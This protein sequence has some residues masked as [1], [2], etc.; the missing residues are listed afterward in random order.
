MNFFINLEYFG[1]FITCLGAATAL[2]ISSEPIFVSLILTKFN[3]LACLIIATIGNWLG[4][5]INYYIGR[6]GKTKWI[7]KYLKIK[8]S[9]IINIQQKIYN[10]SAFMAFFCFLPFVG[11][12]IAIILGFAK[13]NIIIVNITMFVGKFLRYL[14]LLNSLEYII[15]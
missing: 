12:I 2:P 10:K 13:A 1:L 4:G 14:L 7:E 3:P 9:K 15:N 6:L 5:M 11:D 8:H